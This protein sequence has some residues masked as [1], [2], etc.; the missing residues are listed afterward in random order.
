MQSLS[1]GGLQEPSALHVTT[2]SASLQHRG[3]KIR[4]QRRP[5]HLK[6]AAGTRSLDA[7][8][9]QLPKSMMFQIFKAVRIGFD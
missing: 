7:A 6:K 2:A 8:S 9:L 1:A 4:K 5:L 3:S